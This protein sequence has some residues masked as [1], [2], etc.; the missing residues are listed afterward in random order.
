MTD[1]LLHSGPQIGKRECCYII[2]HSKIWI[3]PL[4]ERMNANERYSFGLTHLFARGASFYPDKTRQGASDSHPHIFKSAQTH[5]LYRP[6]SP[7][8]SPWLELNTVRRWLTAAL[9]CYHWMCDPCMRLPLM[10][11][12]PTGH[13]PLLKCFSR[14]DPLCKPSMRLGCRAERK[15][16]GNWGEPHENGDELESWSFHAT[17]WST[18]QDQMIF[19]VLRER[20]RIIILK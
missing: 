17:L 9:C 20:I 6:D 13:Q 8:D 15:P 16:H 2:Q 10:S 4:G 14:F 5:K 3:R 19:K 18:R 1:T 7:S 11:M 12:H